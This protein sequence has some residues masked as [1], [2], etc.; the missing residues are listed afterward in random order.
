MTPQ[1]ALDLTYGAILTAT[2]LAAPVLITAIVVGVLVNVIQTVTS[3]RDMT[4]T[5]V[6]KV[7][8]AAAVSWFAMPWAIQIMSNYFEQ[9]YLM[10][11]QINR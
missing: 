4:L 9:I 1:M 11:W 10:F 5:F 6:P 3:I 7:A 8:A 2:K